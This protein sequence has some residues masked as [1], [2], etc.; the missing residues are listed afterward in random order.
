MSGGTLCHS[1]KV[2]ELQQ[3]IDIYRYSFKQPIEKYGFINFTY[4]NKINKES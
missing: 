4:L 2:V 3:F 1:H